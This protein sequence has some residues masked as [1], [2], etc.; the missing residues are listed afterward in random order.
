MFQSTAKATIQSRHSHLAGTEQVARTDMKQPG[1]LIIN[2]N[3]VIIMCSLGLWIT[4]LMVE[5]LL[6]GFSSSIDAKYELVHR[7]TQW[8]LY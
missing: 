3:N 1:T 4:Q 6:P 5:N 2:N 8:K 7:W